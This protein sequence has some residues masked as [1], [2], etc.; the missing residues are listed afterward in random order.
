MRSFLDFFPTEGQSNSIES[1][2]IELNTM[3]GLPFSFLIREQIGH[4][5]NLFATHF[6][7]L[8]VNITCFLNFDTFTWL[9]RNNTVSNLHLQ[10]SNACACYMLIHG[11]DNV[12]LC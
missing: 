8:S 12:L 10:Y 4:K 11:F 6:L 7:L 3:N 9:H 2:S 5:I 1:N